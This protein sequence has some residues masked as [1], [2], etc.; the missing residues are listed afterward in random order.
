MRFTTKFLAM[1]GTTALL[2]TAVGCSAPESTPNGDEGTESSLVELAKAEGTLTWYSIHDPATVENVVKA[3]TAKYGI[4]VETFRAP[5][6]ELLQRY[7]TER[8]AGKTVADVVTHSAL[9][10]LVEPATPDEFINLAD[11]GLES[12]DAFPKEGIFGDGVAVM[13]NIQPFVIAYNTDLVAEKDV[14]SSW[15]ELFANAE[16]GEV[17]I[18]K[19]DATPL[20]VEFLEVLR[21]AYGD[22]FLT[23]IANSGSVQYAGAVPIAQAVAAGEN[24]YGVSFPSFAYLLKKDGAPI[25]FIAPSVTTGGQTYAAVPSAAPHPNAAKLFV[26]FLFTMEGQ[27]LLT[28]NSGSS[29]LPDVEGAIVIPGL[30]PLGDGEAARANRD[31]ILAL[32]GLQ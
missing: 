1:V 19:W 18:P 5:S 17:A 4:H 9:Q 22:D 15:E 26:D 11:A 2:A 25:E 8:D 29:L 31:S 10:A 16:P 24:A 13:T 14:P 6:S 23:S 21:E 3:F 30:V 7:S 28:T 32:V 20:Y 12:V 27:S